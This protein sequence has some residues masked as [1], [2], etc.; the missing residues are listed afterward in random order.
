MFSS[1]VKAGD[2]CLARFYV[3]THLI[4]PRISICVVY[5]FLQ[6]ASL[7]NSE[8][9]AEFNRYQVIIVFLVF[10]CLSLYSFAVDFNGVNSIQKRIVDV[11]STSK[12]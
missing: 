11:Y 7:S 6:I 4:T 10:I 9:V 12:C 2:C 5:L 1:R 8:I 3:H